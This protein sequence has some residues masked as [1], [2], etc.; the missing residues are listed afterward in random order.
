MTR[1]GKYKVKDPAI[2]EKH[3]ILKNKLGITEKEKLDSV[4][5]EYLVKAYDS[6]SRGY[7]D[8]HVFTAKDI[9]D[10]NKLFLGDIYEWAGKWR[11]VDLSSEEIR[12]CHAAYIPTNIQVFSDDL[13]SKVTPFTPDLPKSVI[14]ERLAKI[15]GEL[16]VIHPFR[17]GNGRTTR[18][19]CDLLLMQAGY[20]PMRIVSFYNE[21]FLKRYHR[22]IQLVWHSKDY[23]ALIK[24]FEPLIVRPE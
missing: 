15:H 7:S 14:L 10:L 17:D 8:D 4:E 23:S 22:A 20:R 5:T 19:L 16:I 1:S 11:T 21:D 18:L 3:G 24:L 9:M 12:Y 6:A 2:D 13:L